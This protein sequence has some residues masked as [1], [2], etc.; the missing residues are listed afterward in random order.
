[1][2]VITEGKGQGSPKSLANTLHRLQVRLRVRSSPL[3]P[4]TPNWIPAETEVE[5]E[6]PRYPPRGP[7]REVSS[8]HLPP[9]PHKSADS[10]ACR[11]CALL[12]EPTR[13]AAMARYCVLLAC[14]LLALLGL[15]D[16]KKDPDCCGPVVPRRE[17]RAL[18]SECS[19]TLKQPVRYVVISHTAGSSCNTPDLCL[20]Q[21]RNVQYYHARTL[22]WCDV[23]YK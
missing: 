17:W 7:N 4:T 21:V 2:G 20:Q 3:P 1:M 22:G 5:P 9:P 14:A 15:G 18:E 23:A 16:G 10:P 13:P 12:A 11:H 19:K 8:C 6:N